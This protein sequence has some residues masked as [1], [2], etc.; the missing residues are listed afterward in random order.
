[1]EPLYPNGL[2]GVLPGTKC[3]ANTYTNNHE[4]IASAMLSDPAIVCAGR[5][6]NGQ[7]HVI[8]GAVAGLVAG[9]QIGENAPG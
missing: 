8:A 2:S 9:S 7:R 4:L 5:R 1:M 3:I 6:R